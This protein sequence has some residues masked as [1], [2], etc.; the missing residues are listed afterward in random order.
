M[1]CYRSC[2]G[3]IRAPLEVSLNLLTSLALISSLPFAQVSKR[4]AIL[5]LTNQLFRI[6]FRINKLNL[7]KPLIRA[8]ENCGALYDHFSTKDQVCLIIYSPKIFPRP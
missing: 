8:V 5:N 6:Y 1:E 2:V 4:L 7:L 3:D